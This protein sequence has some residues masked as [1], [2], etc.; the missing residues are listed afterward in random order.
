MIRT[1]LVEDGFGI[2]R[3]PS[4]SIR[5]RVQRVGRNSDRRSSKSEGGSVFRRFELPVGAACRA[6]MACPAIV[7]V[8]RIM[9]NLTAWRKARPM[10]STSAQDAM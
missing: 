6:C 10:H 4:V 9:Q 5:W 3:L 1:V 2:V 7:C 8:S